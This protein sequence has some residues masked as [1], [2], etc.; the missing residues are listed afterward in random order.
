[1]TNERTPPA[2]PEDCGGRWE[3]LVLDTL[4]SVEDPANVRFGR[5]HQQREVD[6]GWFRPST[7]WS[8]AK[9]G[10]LP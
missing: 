4:L 9:T 5:D 6:F 10:R 7:C 3:H 2:A 1:V 8:G